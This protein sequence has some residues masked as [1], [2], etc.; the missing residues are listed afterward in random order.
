MSPSSCIDCGALTP[1]AIAAKPHWLCPACERRRD[2]HDD[3]Y[4]SERRDALAERDA[5]E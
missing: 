4:D 5:G 2:E 1:R 3:R